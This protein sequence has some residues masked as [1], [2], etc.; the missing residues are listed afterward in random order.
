MSPI[1]TLQRVVERLGLDP[2]WCCTAR[3]QPRL[4]LLLAAGLASL[5]LWTTLGWALLH[6]MAWLA[7]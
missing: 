5:A 7:R 2:A 3:G 6:A 1:A 4:E